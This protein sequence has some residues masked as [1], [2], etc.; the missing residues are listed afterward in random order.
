MKRS[1]FFRVASNE[2]G[3]EREGGG[4]REKGRKNIYFSSIL[5]KIFLREALFSHYG[6][7]LGI[8]LICGFRN[9]I[10]VV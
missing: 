3:R 2:F 4:E 7:L 1:L 9:S 10:S 8:A 5:C 6:V